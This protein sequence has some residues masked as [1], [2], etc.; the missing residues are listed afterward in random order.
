MACGGCH[1]FVFSC[2]FVLVFR[3]GSFGSEVARVLGGGLVP[4][5]L[6]PFVCFVFIDSFF[7]IS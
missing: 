6:C 2:N 4:G 1:I 7:L 5:F 3:S